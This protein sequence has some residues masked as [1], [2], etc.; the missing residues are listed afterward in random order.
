MLKEGDISDEQQ[1]KWIRGLACGLQYVH[2]NNVIHADLNSAN[3]IISRDDVA[4][5]LD[6]GGSQID[7]QEALANYDEYSYRSPE[8]PDPPIETGAPP[9]WNETKHMSQDGRMSY[10]ED[11][12]RQRLFPSAEN[13][14][15]GP[16]IMG[17]WQGRYESMS[18][19]EQ[20]LNI[21]GVQRSRP[22]Q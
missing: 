13:L 22:Q 19:L 14:R 17:C 8:Y 7:D 9:F 10:V 6:F 3:A 21:M 4:M 5:W 11:M 18:D 12:Y 2:E 20:D 15:F 16:I 1:E